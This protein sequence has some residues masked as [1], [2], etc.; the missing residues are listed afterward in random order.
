VSTGAG[1]GGITALNEEAFDDT[2]KD[3]V[4]VVTFEAKLNEVS[5]GFGS[6]FR[7]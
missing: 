3:G 6:F 7:P 2:M 1:A 5:N 4:I